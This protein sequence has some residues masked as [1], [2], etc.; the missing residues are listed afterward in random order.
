MEIQVVEHPLIASRMTIMRDER[1]N[2]AA[3]RAALADLGAMLVYEA[4]KDLELQ[5]FDVQTPWPPLRVSAWLSH[6]LSCRLSA[7]AWA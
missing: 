4:A 7:L 2:N 3:F 1:S 5:S 6:R